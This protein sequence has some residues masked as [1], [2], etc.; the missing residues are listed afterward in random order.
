MTDGIWTRRST[1]VADRIPMRLRLAWNCLRGRPAAYR[2]SVTGGLHVLRN[3]I[4]VECTL[5]LAETGA[6]AAMSVDLDGLHP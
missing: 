3:T 4:V 6:V 5:Q 1:P 2:L